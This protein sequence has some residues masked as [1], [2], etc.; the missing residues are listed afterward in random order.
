LWYQCYPGDSSSWTL[1][2]HCPIGSD[3]NSDW[4]NCVPA[5]ARTFYV[6]R[7]QD[8]HVDPYVQVMRSL[9][10]RASADSSHPARSCANCRTVLILSFPCHS[11]TTLRNRSTSPLHR[12][13]ITVQLETRILWTLL[14][15][16]MSNMDMCA[17]AHILRYITLIVIQYADTEVQ[18]FFNGLFILD[19]LDHEYFAD[20]YSN[21]SHCNVYPMYILKIY[22]FVL[23]EKCKWY[24]IQ[25][26]RKISWCVNIC[27]YIT[28][29]F[30]H[31][32][33]HE[34]IFQ[35]ITISYYIQSVNTTI[36]WT[37]HWDTY[38]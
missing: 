5:R 12:Q 26:L 37:Q 27:D 3:W 6:H 25:Y 35:T 32:F 31:L 16:N 8:A 34:G 36:M 9:T 23:I 17:R 1:D 13:R 30:K 33:I 22:S 15:Y 38:V 11:R 14:I 28:S 24:F 19:S 21:V 7:P 10:R 2:R 29:N 4:R 20:I 18:K